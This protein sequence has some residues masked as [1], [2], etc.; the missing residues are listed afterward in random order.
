MKSWGAASAVL[1]IVLASLP[2]A[3]AM[4]L[5]AFPS[6]EARSPTCFHLGGPPLS[7]PLGWLAPLLGACPR[8]ARADAPPVGPRV[9][10]GAPASDGGTGAGAVAE[11]P[12]DLRRSLLDA[13]LLGQPLPASVPMG[14]PLEDRSRPVGAEGRFYVAWDRGCMTAGARVGVDDGTEAGGV[15]Q[16]RDPR[17]A[18]L[19]PF[20]REQA[21]RAPLSAEV[22]LHS[23]DR[24]DAVGLPQNASA[25]A[26]EA[27]DPAEP[28]EVRLQDMDAA[29]EVR[30]RD[31]ERASVD[32]HLSALATP[33][34][35]EAEAS[36]HMQAHA[37]GA[38]ASASVLAAREARLSGA[39]D[40]SAAGAAAQPRAR[41]EEPP[42]PPAQAPLADPAHGRG[43]R[44]FPAV[45]AAPAPAQAPAA[46]AAPAAPA[47][48]ARERPDALLLSA[49]A[50]APVALAVA[51]FALYQRVHRPDA[52]HHPAR[53]ALHEGLGLFPHGATAGMAASAAGLPRKTAEYH[54]TYLAR[55]GLVRMH[56]DAEGVTRYSLQAVP[57]EPSLASKL[58]ESVRTN[59]GATTAQLAALL[60]VSRARVDRRLKELVLAGELEAERD[61]GERRYRPAAGA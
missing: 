43:P 48:L 9:A 53:A 54:L 41:V 57:P 22:F 40:L 38:N 52:L 51:A 12:R 59:P 3:A 60:G 45:A 33:A 32:G 31:V 37:A 1:A 49:A 8:G 56:A 17:P 16:A 24:P 34:R 15:R 21:T 14:T 36:A 19:P 55:M 2:P 39:H 61:A 25:S 28:P 13:W 18:C 29:T 6:P 5:D 4:G 42:A 46:S 50:L 20:L 47:W 27:S 26:P 23:E 58:L 35:G 44:A 7:G 11:S 30:P 10:V